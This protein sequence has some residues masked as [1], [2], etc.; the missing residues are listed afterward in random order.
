MP[1]SQCCR[2]TECPAGDLKLAGYSQRTQETHLERV[3]SVPKCYSKY[4]SQLSDDQIRDYPLYV[5]DKRHYSP[6][7]LRIASL[8]AINLL[9][10]VQERGLCRL[11]RQPVLHWVQ[12]TINHS[13]LVG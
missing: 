13:R 11:C 5:G 9:R 8:M 6:S 4:P 12:S 7:S 10:N 3:D 2:I 1:G